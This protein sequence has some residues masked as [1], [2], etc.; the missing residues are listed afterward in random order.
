[1]V[2]YRCK[3]S[4]CSKNASHGPKAEVLLP[5]IKTISCKA[6]A[7]NLNCLKQIISSLFSPKNW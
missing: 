2:T 5:R 4:T 3:E 1:M 6:K 7:L